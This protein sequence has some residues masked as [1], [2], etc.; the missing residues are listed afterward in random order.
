MKLK[1][2]DIFIDIDSSAVKVLK[3]K[4]CES[5]GELKYYGLDLETNVKGWWHK[6]EIAGTEKEIFGD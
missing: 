6:L 5:C 1:Q 4:R 3:I 2:G